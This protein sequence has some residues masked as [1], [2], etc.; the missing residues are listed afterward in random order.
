MI[1]ISLFYLLVCLA[2]SCSIG[3]VAGAILSSKLNNNDY[4]DDDDSN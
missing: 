1:S 3:F 2:L 4:Y